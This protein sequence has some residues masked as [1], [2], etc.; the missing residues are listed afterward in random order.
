MDFKKPLNLQNQL[1][2]Q[3]EQINVPLIGTNVSLSMLK[4]TK[5]QSNLKDS[6]NNNKGF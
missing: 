1:S 4:N 6:I 3:F 5:R 2:E